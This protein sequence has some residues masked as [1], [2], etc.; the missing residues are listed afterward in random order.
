MCITQLTIDTIGASLNRS[1]RTI[2]GHHESLGW[3]S[4]RQHDT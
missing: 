3:R 4:I 2:A 1:I